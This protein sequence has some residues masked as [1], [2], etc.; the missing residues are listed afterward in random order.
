MSPAHFPNSGLSRNPARAK[1]P[2]QVARK[3]GI[4]DRES[5]VWDTWAGPGQERQEWGLGMWQFVC[6]QVTSYWHS[7]GRQQGLGK[8]FSTDRVPEQ[9]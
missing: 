6:K 7:V 3:P 4:G 9:W 2:F 5:K 1:S 8:T